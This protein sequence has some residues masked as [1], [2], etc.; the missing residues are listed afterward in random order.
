MTNDTIHR[1]GTAPKEFGA[2]QPAPHATAGAA[3]PAHAY[4]TGGHAITHKRTETRAI[5]FTG[6]LTNKLLG[7][8]PGEDF[9]RLLP[10]LEPVSLSH[11]DRLYEMGERVAYCYLVE[12]AVVSQIHL[13][14]DGSTTEVALIGNEGMVGLSAVFG[15]PAP[16][17]WSEVLVTGNALRVRAEVL[18]EEFAR[19]G[20]LQRVLLAYTSERL[21]HLS[22]RAV[23]NGRH[24]LAGRLCSWL[25]MLDDRLEKGVLALTHEEMARHMGTR[26]AGVSVIATQLREAGVISYNRGRVSILDRRLLEASACECYRTLRRQTQHAR[27]AGGA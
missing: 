1:R 16:S 26:R 12:S 13:L 7:G 22:Q 25:L 4:A 8:L 27:D 23:C 10:H 19:G 15:S 18:R 2:R 20:A 11:G 3:R 6:L 9:A 14:A 21:A 5:P 24:L 17:H